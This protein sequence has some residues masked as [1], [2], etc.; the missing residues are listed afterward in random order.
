VIGRVAA[1]AVIIGLVACA[2]NKK[3]E[4]IYEEPVTSVWTD[5]APPPS[6][7][8]AVPPPTDASAPAQTSPPAQP[9][10]GDNPPPMPQAGSAPVYPQTFPQTYPPPQPASPPPNQQPPSGWRNT[11]P[12]PQPPPTGFPDPS[13]TTVVVPDQNPTTQTTLK[14]RTGWVRGGYD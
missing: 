4:L 11:Q 2:S 13:V 9:P 6:P 5:R 14:R 1:I 7:A 3:V 12:P 8:Q 10:A